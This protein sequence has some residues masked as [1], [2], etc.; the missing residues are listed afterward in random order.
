MADFEWNL[1]SYVEINRI[2]D[3]VS[4]S[5]ICLV[6]AWLNWYLKYFLK[7]VEVRLVEEAGLL[8]YQPLIEFN[9][10]L[11]VLFVLLDVSASSQLSFFA[12]QLQMDPV[13][14]L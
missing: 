3:R 6:D 5:L 11:M 12:H 14:A 2:W 8:K 9:T 7:N 10:K 1:Q 13:Y 4:K